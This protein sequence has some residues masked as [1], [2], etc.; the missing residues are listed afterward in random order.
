MG[1]QIDLTGQRFGR[2]TVISFSKLNKH[3]QS[4]WLCRCDCGNEI[5]TRSMCLVHGKTHSCGCFQK[6][7]I[8]KRNTTHGL[9]KT[10]LHRIWWGMKQ[11]CCDKNCRAYINYGSRGILICNEWH[12]D[13]LTFYNWA[14]S[15]GYSD[16]LSIDRINNDGNY[17]PSNCRWTT[18]K[19][20]SNNRRTRKRYV[21]K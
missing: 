7:G 6:E 4:L 13:F 16:D 2:L 5:V 17:E 21:L 20:Q 10:R 19:E 8:V 3:R 9:T 18:A 11:R 12:D 1:K 15:H 14:V